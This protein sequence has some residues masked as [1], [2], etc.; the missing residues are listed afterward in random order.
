MNFRAGSG[1]HATDYAAETLAEAGVAR[2]GRLGGLSR[3]SNRS[4]TGHLDGCNLYIRGMV[5][6][7]KQELSTVRAEFLSAIR[8]MPRLVDDHRRESQDAVAALRVL[9]RPARAAKNLAARVNRDSF[10]RSVS[11]KGG[12][13]SMP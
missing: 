12:P 11:L 7:Q 9:K 4:V 6:H 10:A 13:P 1:I 3:S 8:E 2:S 5:G